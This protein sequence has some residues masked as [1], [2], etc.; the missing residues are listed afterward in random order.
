MNSFLHLL[1][2]E[3]GFTVR[4]VM[5]S[6][7]EAATTIS[8]ALVSRSLIIAMVMIGCMFIFHLLLNCMKR[9]RYTSPL[10]C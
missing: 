5:V 7:V 2:V 8:P 1:S 3:T 6:I 10:V 4:Y 9:Y